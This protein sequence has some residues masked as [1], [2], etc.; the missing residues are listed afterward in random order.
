MTAPILGY[1]ADILYTDSL[2]REVCFLTPDE[3][4]ETVGAPEIAAAT[5]TPLFATTVGE[6]VASAWLVVGGGVSPFI[7][8]DWL[9]AKS[10][11][12]AG[13]TITSLAPTANGG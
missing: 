8:D 13:A 11:L 2:E 12:E 3:W 10:Y 6:A 5:Y 7:T 4:H 1:A 9:I